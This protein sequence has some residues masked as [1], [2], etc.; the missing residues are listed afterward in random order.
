MME[1]EVKK[2]R[3]AVQAVVLQARQ[4]KA[5]EFTGKY[6]ESVT[7]TSKSGN[8]FLLHLTSFQLLSI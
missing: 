1:G 8:S 2:E 3:R 4:K 5:V 6:A 7:Y